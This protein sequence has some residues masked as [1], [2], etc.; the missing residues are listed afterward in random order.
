MWKR[1]TTSSR[2]LDQK[3]N[4]FLEAVLKLP[5]RPTQRIKRNHLGG[6]AEGIAELFRGFSNAVG[7]IETKSV[8]VREFQN[9]FL[10]YKIS[11]N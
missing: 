3:R 10:V 8:D 6:K 7:A 1:M 11:I 5:P 2:H 4:K 9:S